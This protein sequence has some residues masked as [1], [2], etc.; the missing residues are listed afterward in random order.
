M[1]SALFIRVAAPKRAS[2]GATNGITQM[3]LA[4]AWIIGPA[5]VVS[6]FSYSTQEGH[7]AWLVYYFLI[8]IAFF[9]IG[10]SL[11]IPRDPSLWEDHQ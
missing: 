3:F 2:L 1:A 7:D 4:G 5:S 6:V 9:A 8:A 10:V 11:L